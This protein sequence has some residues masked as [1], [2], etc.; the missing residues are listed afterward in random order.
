[1]RALTPPVAAAAPV[2][3]GLPFVDSPTGLILCLAFYFVVVGLGFAVQS[4]A[5]PTTKR[6]DPAWLRAIVLLHNLFLVVLSLYMCAGCA[7]PTRRRAPQR[8]HP[9]HRTPTEARRGRQ[10]A[11]PGRRSRS[12]FASHAAAELARAALPRSVAYYAHE[13]R[14]IV[15]GNPYK[16]SE[17]GMATMIYIFFVSKIYEFMDT[18]IMLLKG[19]LHQARAAASPEPVAAR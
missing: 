9:A 7:S 2:T 5:A 15:W 17:H 13:G 1:M 3:A 19:N 14:Y 6:A 16:A 8:A 4:G 11:R 12:P 10:R 18:F